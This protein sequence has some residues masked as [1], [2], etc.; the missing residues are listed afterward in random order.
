VDISFYLYVYVFFGTKRRWK[1]GEEK[2]KKCEG[3][4]FSIK[5]CLPTIYQKLWNIIFLVYNNYQSTKD[6]SNQ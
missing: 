1:N 6:T 3:Q 4:I 5:N 2:I